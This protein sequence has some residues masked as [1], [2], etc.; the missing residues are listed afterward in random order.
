MRGLLVCS[1]ISAALLSSAAPA[2]AQGNPGPLDRAAALKLD[3]CMV[4]KATKDRVLAVCK[5]DE[6]FA[7]LKR[8]VKAIPGVQVFGPMCTFPEGRDKT[9]ELQVE[10][11]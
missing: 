11:S 3:G 4:R 2:L 9:C 5:T 7:E 8:Q 6:Q 10:R 1:I